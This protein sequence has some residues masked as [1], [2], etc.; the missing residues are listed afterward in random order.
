MYIVPSPFGTFPTLSP[1]GFSV[2]PH[3]SLNNTFVFP[4]VGLLSLFTSVVLVLPNQRKPEVALLDVFP[5][6]YRTGIRHLL[7]LVASFR[8]GLHSCRFARL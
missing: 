1:L 8:H 5:N 3:S 4:P 7:G 2:T 6:S